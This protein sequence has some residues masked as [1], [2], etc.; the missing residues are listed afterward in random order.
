MV[1]VE[2]NI[3]PRLGMLES[4]LR[5]RPNQQE[6]IIVNLIGLRNTGKSV[7]LSQ[8]YE[9]FAPAAPVI[10]LDFA[11]QPLPLVQRSSQ[12]LEA[13]VSQL[14]EQVEA[15]EYLSIEQSPPDDPDTHDPSPPEGDAK[16]SLLISTD[17]IDIESSIVVL[18][19][20]ISELNAWK[21]VQAELLSPL[22]EQPV[23]IVCVSREQ[24]SWDYWRLRDACKELEIQPFT[25]AEASEYFAQQGGYI[26]PIEIIP[27]LIGEELY[28]YSLEEELREFQKQA[29]Y[30]PVPESVTLPLSTLPASDPLL[31]YCGWLRTFHIEVM[32]ELLELPALETVLA[33][34]QDLR[35]RR[36]MLRTA[37]TRWRNAHYIQVN[38]PTERLIQPLRQTLERHISENDPELYLAIISHAA[39]VY[40]RRALNGNATSDVIRSILEWLY[41][42]TMVLLTLDTDEAHIDWEEQLSHLLGETG[43]P[44]SL[45]AISLYNDQEVVRHLNKAKLLPIVDRYLQTN[46]MTNPAAL[47]SEQRKRKQAVQ[48]RILASWNN[49][50]TLA[51]VKTAYPGGVK[52]LLAD[53]ADIADHNGCF[54]MTDLRRTM[55]QHNLD[56]PARRRVIRAIQEAGLVQYNRV[57]QQFELEPAARNLLGSEGYIPG[58]LNP[59]QGEDY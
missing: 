4:I 32:I 26:V 43:L 11:P 42:A 49:N 29:G 21:W 9:K 5:L 17:Y 59:P 48:Q 34:P 28:P 16:A 56:Q 53:I 25:S 18:L 57:T 24:L 52:I 40:A 20:H 33:L 46:T 51:A 2:S 1:S 37:L 30:W 55:Q 6:S 44:V 41:Y 27:A 50:P 39:A 12:S 15:L 14:S 54:D 23:L 7:V 3:I 58:S 47:T 13:I 8:L 45:L 22:I 10:W 38:D 35:E 36:S 19:D 31:Y